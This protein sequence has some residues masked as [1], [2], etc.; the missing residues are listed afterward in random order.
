MIGG[1]AHIGDAWNA[2]AL[3][4]EMIMGRETAPN[5]ITL[6]NVLTACS[7]GG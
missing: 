7:R 4:D 3:F 6:V 5:Y 2:L 1:Y